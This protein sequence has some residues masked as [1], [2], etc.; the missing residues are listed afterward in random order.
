[1]FIEFNSQNSFLDVINIYIGFFCAARYDYSGKETKVIVF[2]IIF[3]LY[4][5]T[6]IL[7][8]GKTKDKLCIWLSK[9][10]ESIN[11]STSNAYS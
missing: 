3:I 6:R 10:F 1:M 11:K 2:I 4:E 5:V 8:V 9:I 7:S